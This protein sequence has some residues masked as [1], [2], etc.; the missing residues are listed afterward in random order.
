M[1][2]AETIEYVSGLDLG[3]A[4]E[5]TA[6]AV[7]ERRTQPDVH[8]RQR[9]LSMYSVRHLERFPIGAPYATIFERVTKLFSEKLLPGNVLLADQTAVGDHD[10]C[11]LWRASTPGASLHCWLPS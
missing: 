6:L 2:D 8:P 10:R 9:P 3:Q 5:Y 4:N 1:A 7:L 11:G